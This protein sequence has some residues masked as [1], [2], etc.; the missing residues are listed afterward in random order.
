MNYK[1]I[2][3]PKELPENKQQN[4]IN[5]NSKPD[6]GVLQKQAKLLLQ[7]KEV[8]SKKNFY[9]LESTKEYNYLSNQINKG[10]IVNV[11]LNVKNSNNNIQELCKNEKGK[12]YKRIN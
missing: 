6:N 12:K 11:N 2:I 5:E 9:I 7:N 1:N 4:L 8:K 3:F 10:K